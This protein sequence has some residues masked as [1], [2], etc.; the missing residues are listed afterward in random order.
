MMPNYDFLEIGDKKRF[1]YER[2]LLSAELT[3]FSVKGKIEATQVVITKS[4]LFIVK[5]DH[6]KRDIPLNE[7]ESLTTSVNSNEFIVHVEDNYDERFS[8]AKNKSEILQMILYLQTTSNSPTVQ[9]NNFSGEGNFKMKVY[10]ISD[11]T[12][13]IY[14]TTPDDIEQ[15]HVLRPDEKY[16]KMINYKEFLELQ[17][18]YA[19]KKEQR[20]KSTKTIYSK[21]GKKSVSIEDF[22][23]LKT[24]GKGAHGKVLLCQKIGSKN[25]YYAMKILKK[26]HI[27]DANQIE[28]TIAEKMIL[29]C[30]THPFLVSLKQAF[31]NETKIYFVMDFMKG[32]ELFQHL[33]KLKRFTEEQTRFVAACIITALG[34]L[35]NKDYIYRDLK[36]ENVLLDEK[37]YAKLTD[38]GLAKCLSV[39]E[40]A[41]TFCG[42]P[43]YL[44]PEIILDKGC[45]RPA[46]WWSLGILV[47]EMLFG[48]PPFYSK[49]VQEMYKKTLLQPLKFV[50]KII[51]SPEA[52]D[53]IAGLLVKA[54][55]KRLGTIADSLEVMNH[56]W[57]KDF[58]WAKLLD[59]N[60]TPPYNPLENDWEKNFDPG[61]T[62][63]PARDS[64]CTVDPTFF[65]KFSSQFKI[66]DYN[67]DGFNLSDIA[68]TG[69][70][71]ST[72]IGNIGLAEPET[73]SLGVKFKESLIREANKLKEEEKTSEITKIVI[74]SGCSKKLKFGGDDDQNTTPET[75]SDN[76]QIDAQNIEKKEKVKTLKNSFEITDSQLKDFET[77]FFT[78]FD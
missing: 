62:K 63:E 74:D 21:E 68:E 50:N 23:L 14:T 47:Y 42:T 4:K 22:E 44:A 3:R 64:L 76:G 70:V 37:G 38:F 58:P 5:D 19:E 69:K 25:E 46:D 1:E 7:I 41:K 52:K 31:Q 57:F 40:V 26:Q 30:L 73:R 56:P 33:R 27:I 67:N 11:L 59:K 53:F 61:F 16:R 9:K 65:E 12:L 32:G 45:N 55:S 78:N 72:S 35:H 71:S 66:F 39:G 77:A 2:V 17:T 36:P 43:E 15:G 29:S 75:L 28:H 13:D 6:I 8:C 20:S 60:L 34:H 10:M 49:D 48:I 54:P 24:L 51:I 18:K